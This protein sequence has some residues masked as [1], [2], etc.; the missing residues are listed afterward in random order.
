MAQTQALRPSFAMVPDLTSTFHL[1]VKYVDALENRKMQLT[2]SGRL[3]RKPLVEEDSRFTKVLIGWH[4]KMPDT[5]TSLRVLSEHYSSETCSWIPE[6]NRQ[7]LLAL[8]LSSCL[9]ALVRE[10]DCAMQSR[11]RV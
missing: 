2:G 5:S 4:D 8:A 7:L 11:N 9:A 10:G 6:K 3:G 1:M